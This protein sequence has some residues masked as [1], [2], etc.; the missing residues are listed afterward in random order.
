M[1]Q[2]GVT[3]IAPPRAK[4][5]EAFAG[6]QCISGIRQ[7]LCGE[8]WA[9]GPYLYSIQPLELPPPKSTARRNGTTTPGMQ[10]AG[11]ACQAYW[12]P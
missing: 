6:S 1:K 12:G 7:V 5:E 3:L 9:A 4:P 2:A 10:T 8:L 11:S